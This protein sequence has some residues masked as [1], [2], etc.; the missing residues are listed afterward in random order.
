MLMSQVVSN[1]YLI[2]M[3]MCS[4]NFKNS[5]QNKPIQH[6]GRGVTNI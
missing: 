2:L 6:T 3:S 1:P 4:L 5:I